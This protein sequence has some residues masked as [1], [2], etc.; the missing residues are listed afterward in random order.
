MRH[1]RSSCTKVHNGAE[2]EDPSL[3]PIEGSLCSFAGLFLCLQ[4]LGHRGGSLARM[5]HPAGRSKDRMLGL[6]QEWEWSDVF[7]AVSTLIE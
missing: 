6:S 2:Y 5:K 3:K 1:P 7:G 4:Q